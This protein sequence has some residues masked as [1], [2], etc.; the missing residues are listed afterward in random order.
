MVPAPASPQHR[1]RAP[2][3]P[4]PHA[5]RRF[6][7]EAPSGFQTHSWQCPGC[8]TWAPTLTFSRRRHR[9]LG[10]WF[11]GHRIPP[12]NLPWS[13]WSLRQGAG[14]G[15]TCGL[16]VS[17]D[18]QAD[19]GPPLMAVRVPVPTEAEE[20]FEFVVVS[21]TGQTWHFEASTAEERELWVQSVQAQILASLQGCRSAKDK[22]GTGAR[23]GVGP[24]L[25]HVT[26]QPPLSP[27]GRPDW[28]TRTR[29]WRCRP[30]APFAATASAST[31]TPPVSAGGRRGLG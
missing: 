20:S 18:G 29:R 12:W 24:Y 3:T 11:E 15:W 17:L 2:I 5:R 9:C 14:S 4:S 16:A 19:K 6:L 1:L 13:T 10:Q 27:R 23:G 26:D 25:C 31:V 28:G 22:V 21:L 8:P 30:S 7:Q